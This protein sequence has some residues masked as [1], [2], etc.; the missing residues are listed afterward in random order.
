MAARPASRRGA[1]TAPG[2]AGR[3]KSARPATQSPVAAS[4]S[5]SGGGDGRVQKK[6]RVVTEKKKGKSPPKLRR[7]GAPRFAGSGEFGW[8]TWNTW[9]TWKATQILA[10][11]KRRGVLDQDLVDFHTGKRASVLAKHK[12]QSAIASKARPAAAPRRQ[13]SVWDVVFADDDD[14]D[15][16]G[17]VVLQEDEDEGSIGVAAP[18]DSED[19]AMQYAG[20]HNFEMSMMTVA[21]QSAEEEEEET[22]GGDGEEDNLDDDMAMYLANMD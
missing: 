15:D 19:M 7:S 5:P 9:C 11:A 3:K 18:L 1:A 16:G 14:D 21:G 20:D 2:T 6:R 12:Q 10:E 13:G 17:E 22:L 4:G 8:N